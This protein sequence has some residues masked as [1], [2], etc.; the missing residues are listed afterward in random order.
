MGR[1][2]IG[3]YLSRP[4]LIRPSNTSPNHS[5]PRTCNSNGINNTHEV[6]WTQATIFIRTYCCISSGNAPVLLAHSATYSVPIYTTNQHLH[7]WYASS[8]VTTASSLSSSS[9]LSNGIASASVHTDRVEWTEYTVLIPAGWHPHITS[10]GN[11]SMSERYRLRMFDHKHL[12]K[13]TNKQ[14]NKYKYTNC[15]APHKCICLSTSHSTVAHETRARWMH[16]DV[17]NP[18]DGWW[19]WRR[20]RRQQIRTENIHNQP[21]PLFYKSCT[22]TCWW[23]FNNLTIFV[24]AIAIVMHIA[25]RATGGPRQRGVSLF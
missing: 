16:L 18:D 2:S 21:K 6:N 3:I 11:D 19:H 10:T 23:I 8:Q 12:H 15:N 9:S 1:G 20:G 14:M 24:L 4:S 13:Q 5:A 17:Y 7:W 22:S 25:S